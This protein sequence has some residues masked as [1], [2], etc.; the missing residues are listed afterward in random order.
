MSLTAFLVLVGDA[1]DG[2]TLESARQPVVNFLSGLTRQPTE[3]QEQPGALLWQSSVYADESAVALACAK[4]PDFERTIVFD[5]W[6]E[7]REEVLVA[8][9]TS[10]PDANRSD[11]LLVLA[12]YAVWGDQLADR[13]YGEYAFVIVER[14]LGVD[15][16]GHAVFAV[17]DKVGIR[18]LFYSQWQGGMALS[19]FPGALSVLPWVGSEINEGFAAEFL[20]ANIVSVNET[21]YLNV[22]RL[23]GGHRLSWQSGK[24]PRIE[25]YWRP[26][27]RVEQMTEEDAVVRFRKVLVASVRAAS[28]CKGPLGCQ[29]SGGID[30]STVATVVADLIDARELSADNVVGLSQIYPGLECDETPYIDEMQKVVSFDIERLVPRYC[31]LEEADDFTVRMRYP[32]VPFTGTCASRHLEE[33]VRRNGRTILTG[34]GGD[35]L[36]IPTQWAVWGA[37]SRPYEWPAAINYFRQN[38]R[39][40][41]LTASAA[42]KF[43]QLLG[44]AIGSK[45]ANLL[46][47]YVDARR[48]RTPLPINRE[49]ADAVCID[50]RLRAS[51]P[52]RDCRTSASS[53]A[54]NGSWSEGYES[55]HWLGFVMCVERRHPLASARVVEAANQLPL[56]LLDGQTRHT[57]RLLRMAAV[58]RLPAIILDRLGKAEFT[59]SVLP[60]LVRMA[61]AR[62]GLDPTSYEMRADRTVSV[63][64]WPPK[65]VWLLDAAQ[66]FRAFLSVVKAQRSAS[67]TRQHCTEN[68]LEGVDLP[69]RLL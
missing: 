49:W 31:T 29:I 62:L 27:S 68:R 47:R 9:G 16:G 35:E 3:S 42:G 6:I 38:W 10:A 59:T 23:C 18:P 7:N 55:L 4:S 12:G 53:N 11:S 33:H 14:K 25:R 52:P 64:A 43:R 2:S 50:K 63:G 44:V 60:P 45:L 19:N 17:R 51:A 34:E 69:C 15:Q 58:E 28:K 22:S 54:T 66:A 40:R 5:G 61:S 41:M 26:D 1:P 30:S 46:A 24:Q 13:L 36:F 21:L 56:A 8:L 65:Q 57:R 39:R 67:V 20:C 37:F 48:D 32:F